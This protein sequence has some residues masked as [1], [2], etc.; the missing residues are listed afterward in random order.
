MNQ[1]LAIVIFAFAFMVAIVAGFF[2][3]ERETPPPAAEALREH[4]KE[5]LKKPKS[6]APVEKKRPAAVRTPSSYVMSGLNLE[7][8]THRYG[9]HLSFSNEG[10]RVI[11]IS[12]IAARGDEILSPQ[13]VAGFQPSREEAL[14]LR[15]RE[16]FRDAR[17]LLGISDVT[18]FLDPVTAPGQSSGQVIF[19]Q[20]VNGVPVYPGGLVTILVGPDGELRSLDSSVYANPEIANAATLPASAESKLVLYVVQTLPNA[21]LRYAYVSQVRGMQSISDAETGTVL[22]E[23]SRRIE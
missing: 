20:S 11:R 8:F 15:A 13:K 19:Q 2:S 9:E 18:Q 16:I 22:L 6:S 21:V 17:A 12:G 10:S 5:V 14:I 7:T 4:M 3:P 23:R 1:K